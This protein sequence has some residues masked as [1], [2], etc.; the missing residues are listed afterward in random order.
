[1]WQEMRARLGASAV[2]TG[3]DIP[4]RACRDASEGPAQP[5]LALLRPTDTEGIAAALRFCAAQGLAVTV[6]GGMTGLSGG[7]TPSPSSVALSLERLAGI[8]AL[9]PDAGTVLVRAGT[10]L[11]MVQE[12]AAAHG[13][14]YP[15]D[16]NARA[17]CTIGGTIATNAGGNRVIRYGMTRAQVL[18]LEV[19]LADGSILSDLRDLPKNNA[20]F[21]LKQLFIGSEGQ[22]GIV[23]R[24]LL[25]LIPAPA[26]GG[27][28]ILGLAGFDALRA[29]L[30]RARR[31]LGEAL[32]AFEAM[33]PEYW[34][35]VTS[36][37]LPGRR[38]PLAGQHGLYVLIEADGGA[39]TDPQALETC[40]ARLFDDGL[41]E[42]A[43][44]ARSG[45]DVAAFW[46]LREAAAEVSR[47]TGPCLG[48]D[49]GVSP[50]LIGGYV[51]A[52]RAALAS[53][54]PEVRPLF[55]GHAGD[56]N[57][58]VML[59]HPGGFDPQLIHRCDSLLYALVGQFRGTITAEHGLGQL[60]RDWLPLCRSPAEI[61]AMRRLKAA[62]D[63]AGLLNPGKV[64]PD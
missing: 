58:H 46:A 57:L 22:L 29:C 7:A 20:G 13:M 21:D 9:D 6:Q 51:D 12:A 8:E 54:L 44:L 35:P 45:A 39:A 4:A 18:G 60:K 33:W 2:L 19:V 31:D 32:S 28:A 24:A 43:A 59:A 27:C 26:P 61:A 47:V 53:Q 36:G 3:G 10:P 41:V 62:F 49:I 14:L 34:D 63:P 23:T 11:S 5:P 55:F 40:L 16:L 1:M 56:G 64:L 50:G 15:V 37:A 42:D 48:F 30:D 25:R 38:S 52:A 17:S